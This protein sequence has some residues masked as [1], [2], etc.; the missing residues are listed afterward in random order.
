MKTQEIHTLR[1]DEIDYLVNTLSDHMH[2]TPD[3]FQTE[4]LEPLI[5][6]LQAMGGDE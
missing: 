5:E 1:K 3:Q 6:K 4:F 2:S